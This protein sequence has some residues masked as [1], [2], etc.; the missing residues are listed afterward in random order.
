VP[1]DNLA[2]LDDLPAEVRSSL[3]VHAVE[4]LGQALAVVL[5]GGSYAAGRLLFDGQRPDDV[6]PLT[7]RAH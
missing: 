4:E 1:A 6:P 2:D 3:T 7:T 5:R